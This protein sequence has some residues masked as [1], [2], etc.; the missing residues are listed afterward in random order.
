MLREIMCKESDYVMQRER[1][2]D[3][4]TRLVETGRVYREPTEHSHR[5]ELFEI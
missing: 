4:R 2:E 1:E 5:V 3:I